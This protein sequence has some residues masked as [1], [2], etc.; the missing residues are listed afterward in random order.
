MNAVH[1]T[2]RG[3]DVIVGAT[4]MFFIVPVMFVIAFLI[5]LSSKG[6]IFYRQKRLGVMCPKTGRNTEFYLVKFRTMVVDAEKETGAVLSQKCDPRITRIGRF[7][8]RT[9]LDELPQFLNVL[10]GDMSIVGP[11]PERPELTARLGLKIPF[12]EERTRFLKPGITGLAQVS[13]AYDG[14]LT[15]KKPA[16]PIPTGDRESV[17]EGMRIK[18]L[19]DM[20]YSSALERFGSFLKTDFAIMLRTPLVMFVHRSGR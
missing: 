15:E 5:K 7:L 3:M 9:R 4:I 1:I 16:L 2:K 19:Y 11:R 13:L 18:F 8:R 14:N 6:P 10:K 17:T 20:V 12:F